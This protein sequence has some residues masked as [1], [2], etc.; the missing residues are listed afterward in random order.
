MVVIPMTRALLCLVSAAALAACSDEPRAEPVS[1]A[2]LPDDLCA[3]IP[4]SVVTRWRLV[5]ESHETEQGKERAEA[6]CAMSG[7]VDDAPVTLEV[8]LTS[9]GAP[10]ADAARDVVERELAD[11]CAELESSGP[12]RFTDTD[13]RCSTE[14]GARPGDQ[15]G[16]VTEVSASTPSRGLVTVS[17]AHAGPLWQLV[18]AEVVGIS[19]AI[20]NADPADLT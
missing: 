10:D 5:G 15:R 14:T 11:R 17:M 6:R 16:R 18:A 7:R 9:Y 3:A 8:T 2:R 20:A 13:R 12:G 19:G 4:D 1:A